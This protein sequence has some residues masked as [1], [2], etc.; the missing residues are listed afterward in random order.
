MKYGSVTA[1]FYVFTDFTGYSGGVYRHKGSPDYHGSHIVRIIGWGETD[2]KVPYWI[3]ANTWG[4][5]WGENGY[6]RI[7][8]GINDCGI[9]DMV[10]AGEYRA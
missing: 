2:D 5:D 9:E 4:E 6:F 7:I 1:Q 3:V 10:I 8:R